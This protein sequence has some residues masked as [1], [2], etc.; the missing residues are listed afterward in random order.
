M[1]ISHTSYQREKW[2][3]VTDL[4]DSLTA[5]MKAPFLPITR[6]ICPLGTSRIERISSSGASPP[7]AV[8][9]SI[10]AMQT[11]INP[12]NPLACAVSSQLNLT[13]Y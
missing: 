5:V 4:Q 8:I 10:E 1:Y 11:E 9:L 7:S 12:Y 3:R 6:P 2:N 13:C